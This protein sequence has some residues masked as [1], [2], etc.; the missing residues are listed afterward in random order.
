MLG[1]TDAFAY[2]R[3]HSPLVCLFVLAPRSSQQSQDDGVDEEA[4]ALFLRSAA[5]CYPAL[6]Y[7]ALA[8]PLRAALDKDVD[9]A[10]ERAPWRWWRVVRN[11]AGEIQEFPAWEG[12][13]VRDYL[14]RADV[15]AV[16]ALAGTLMRPLHRLLGYLSGR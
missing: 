16:D 5:L 14:R 4:R 2:P 3:S 8:A 15:E 12:E 13:R 10:G 6:K 11:E 9:H 7:V 1:Q